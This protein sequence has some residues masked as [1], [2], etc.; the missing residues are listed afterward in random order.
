[1]TIKYEDRKFN[2]SLRDYLFIQ[3]MKASLSLKRQIR[4]LGILF[5]KQDILL[6][7]VITLFWVF[8]GVG[9]YVVGQSYIA[10]T[11]NPYTISH[12]LWELSEAWFSS[13]ILSFIVGAYLRVGEYTRKI[14]NQHGVYVSTMEDFE[15]IIEKTKNTTEVFTSVVLMLML[16]CWP[17]SAA[18][19]PEPN[20]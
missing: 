14:R 11:D 5:C 16:I 8:F 18:V 6:Y 9:K 3:R 1:M 13:V 12:V 10:T 4:R 17:R 19:H 7:S 2:V 20:R 15:S